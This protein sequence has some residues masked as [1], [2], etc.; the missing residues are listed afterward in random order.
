MEN[1]KLDWLAVAHGAMAHIKER[2]RQRKMEKR[3]ATG[4]F[5]GAA[6]LAAAGAMRGICRFARFADFCGRVSAIAQTVLC[7][8][9]KTM[10]AASR[11]VRFFARR[12]K[13]AATIA[14]IGF[15]SGV[16][17]SSVVASLTMP[18]P[19]MFWAQNSE[20][21]SLS[22]KSQADNDGTSLMIAPRGAQWTL[23]NL[24]G[25]K[26][27]N[28]PK[29][30]SDCLD[31]KRCVFAEQRG[32]GAFARNL[33]WI[34]GVAPPELQALPIEERAAWENGAQL[35]DSGHRMT[36]MILFGIGGVLPALSWM[37]V[38]FG[39]PRGGPARLGAVTH[40]ILSVS[41]VS[42]GI[43]FVIVPTVVA[44]AMIATAHRAGASWEPSTPQ[45]AQALVSLGRVANSRVANW[46]SVDDWNLISREDWRA[47][48][49]QLAKDCVAAGF[50][51][52]TK[53]IRA[54]SASTN[55][56]LDEVADSEKDTAMLGFLI[57]MC[58]IASCYAAVCWQGFNAAANSSWEGG[59][60][61]A[62]R[63]RGWASKGA[64]GAERHRLNTVM[65]GA[66]KASRGEPGE[67]RGATD[68]NHG[69][70]QPQAAQPRR[71]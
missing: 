14:L 42:V 61:W 6:L 57:E 3:L 32:V 67:L 5:N 52:T 64:P 10:N 68:E 33:L 47:G 55:M 71:L 29:K 18:G 54:H 23:V 12:K 30:V 62:E 37:G 48:N 39:R 49:P 36:L 21:K 41:T 53:N 45:E 24:W 16:V 31:A 7:A 8:T 58:F 22:I 34:A 56:D 51:G 20:L 26:A 25:L 63:F 65:R 9:K 70:L 44:V 50:C 66:K 59:D 40:I 38:F 46:T 11:G 43:S 69:S 1:E 28:G 2:R 35:I 17:A 27:D 15:F 4:N 19:D 60:A 13:D